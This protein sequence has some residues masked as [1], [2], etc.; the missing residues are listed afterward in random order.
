MTE[1]QKTSPRGRGDFY[2]AL[3]A[4]SAVTVL[5]TFLREGTLF[6]GQENR[7]VRAGAVGL[8]PVGCSARAFVNRHDHSA[9]GQTALVLMDVFVGEIAVVTALVALEGDGDFGW[10]QDCFCLGCDL[11]LAQGEKV[12]SFH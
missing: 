7:G 1:Q 6:S 8:N 5:R 11:D 3:I 12:C 4:G 2:G 9:V 10:R